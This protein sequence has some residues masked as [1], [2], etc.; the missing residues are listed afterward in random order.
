MSHTCG[1]CPGTRKRCQESWTCKRPLGEML[2]GEN[3]EGARGDGKMSNSS[4]ALTPW[5]WGRERKVLEGTAAWRQFDETQRG[6]PQAKDSSQS[7]VSQKE[8]PAV[9]F[10]PHS[11]TAGSS[12]GDC[13]RGAQAGRI[14]HITVKA[15]SQLRLLQ[16][17]I[18]ETPLFICHRKLAWVLNKFI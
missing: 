1:S 7:V 15:I 3:E 6:S 2:V 8:E 13:H 17:R 16:L 4:V 14:Q 18:W 10:L 11:V 12:Q 9:V 5:W